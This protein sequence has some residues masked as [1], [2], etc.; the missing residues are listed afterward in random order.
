MK[1][2]AL[3]SEVSE[4][5]ASSEVSVSSVME[6]YDH[7]HE[8]LQDHLNQLQY[9]IDLHRKVHKVMPAS[10]IHYNTVRVV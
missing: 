3:Q 6:S 5:D 2:Q 1:V 4:M 10:H 9:L 7:C 8:M